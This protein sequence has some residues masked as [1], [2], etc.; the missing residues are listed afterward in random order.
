M[1]RY[2]EFGRCIHT[3]LEFD[4]QTIFVVLIP[5]ENQR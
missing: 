1:S 4:D 2:V 3:L 5:R